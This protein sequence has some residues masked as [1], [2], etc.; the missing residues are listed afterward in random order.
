MIERWRDHPLVPWAEEMV[1]L[2]YYLGIPFLAT[3]NGLLGADLL[4]VSGTQWAK[5]KSV[6]GFL[7]EDWARGA[8]MAVT[9]VFVV[10]GLWFAARRFARWAGLTPLMPGFHGP[11]W[12]R[13][14]HVLY[15]QSHWAF[16]RSGPIL[17]LDDV[18]WGAFAGLAL[19][20]LESALN[21][22]H[23]WRLRST[24]TAGPTL[25]RLGM[26]WV[27]TLLFLGTQNLWLI[28]GVHLALAATLGEKY[29]N[30]YSYV[31]E[32]VR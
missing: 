21:P 27:S 17:W 23:W 13:F 20:L 2:S 3:V 18:Y 12:Q 28:I 14:L 25:I 10:M 6:Q 16:Y 31:D 26:A 29:A 7:W 4:G 22:A 24:D 5:G 9:A 1:R 15:D 8:G 32:A 11:L 30:G 19:V